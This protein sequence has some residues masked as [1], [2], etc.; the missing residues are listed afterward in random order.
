[1]CNL[2]HTLMSLGPSKGH[3]QFKTNAQVQQSAEFQPLE[4]L[5]RDVQAATGERLSMF[6]SFM[7]ER[8]SVRAG[9]CVAGEE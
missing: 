2:P 7:S 6:G 1:M 9:V 4:T 3:A 8:A 5:P